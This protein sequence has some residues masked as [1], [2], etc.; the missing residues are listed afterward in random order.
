MANFQGGG[1]RHVLGDLRDDLW[2]GAV[3]LTRAPLPR[4]PERALSRGAAAAWGWPLIGAGLGLWA[5]AVGGLALWL[6]LPPV[7]AA[8]LA[9]AAQVAATG[10]LHEDGLADCADGLWGGGTPAR[11]L[12]IMRDSRL[13]SYGA[14]AL[15]FG[16]GLRWAALAALFTAGWAAGA[17]ALLAAGALSR[18]VMPA[19]MAALPPARADGLS[20][21][22]GRPGRGTVALGGALAVLLAWAALGAFPFAAVTSCLAL[23]LAWG[24]AARAKLGGQTGDVLGAGQQLAEIA[25]LLALAAG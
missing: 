9:L 25:V 19:L 4:L 23:A 16:L 15:V 8:G 20:R 11:R 24:A 18:A 10:A 17:A 12:E 22:A 3:L 1:A 5:A 2:H 13:G 14:L 6:G 21:A 7:L